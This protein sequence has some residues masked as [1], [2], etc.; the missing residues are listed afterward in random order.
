MD[1]ALTRSG[2]NPRGRRY[3]GPSAFIALALVIAAPSGQAAEIVGTR[4]NWQVFRN[5]N[6]CGITRRYEGPGETEMT[7][8]KYT[9]ETIRIMITKTGWSARQGKLYDISY[10][11]NGTAYGGAKAVGTAE[12]GR[13][14]FVSTFA[15]GFSDDFAKGS[16]LQVRLEDREIERLPLSDSGAAMA[17][18]D[19]CLAPVRAAMAV[20][21]REQVRRAKL[22]KDPFAPPPK[23]S[24]PKGRAPKLDSP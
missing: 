18:V 2:M 4:G 17:L 3:Q 10:V 13:N 9:D 22:P 21:E 20:T 24:R 6:S 16:L 1:S 15:A 14:G 7:V 12:N 11:L 8:I 23:T 19:D 5:S